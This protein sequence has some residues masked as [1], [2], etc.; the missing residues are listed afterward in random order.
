M[1][2]RLNLS[3]LGRVCLTG[4]SIPRCHESAFVAAF[5]AY[6][7][8]LAATGTACSEHFA[9]IGA[10]HTGTE[11]MLISSFAIGRLE[12]AFHTNGPFSKGLQR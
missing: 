9:A 1:N 11:P 10:S 2:L 7:E 5:V 6:S 4:L 12:C 8:A 3:D